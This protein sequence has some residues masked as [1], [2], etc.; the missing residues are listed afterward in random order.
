MKKILSGILAA[1]LAVG[2][3]AGC[4]CSKTDSDLN[5]DGKVEITVGNWPVNEGDYL[6]TITTQKE[7]FERDNPTMAIKPDN[8]AFSLDTFYSKAAAGMLPDLYYS[9]LTEIAAI[10]SGEYYTNISE[11]LKRAGYEGKINPAVLELITAE[12][13][14]I[15][16]FPTNAYSLG[17]AYNVDLFEK[18]GL[19]NEDGT[20]MQPKT[21]EEVAQFAK[22]ITEATGKAGFIIPTIDNCG[23]WLTTPIAWGYGVDFMEQDDAGNWKATFDCPEM[24]ETLQFISDLK[25]KHNTFLDNSLISLTEEYKQFALGNVG[26]IIASGDFT[27]QVYSYEMPL[28]HIGIMAIPAGPV[29][30]VT[31]VGGG[32]ATIAD[33]AT[34]RQVDV[35]I[36]WLE[37][38]GKGMNV[39]ATADPESH[40]KTMTKNKQAIGIYGMSV[41]SDD[42]PNVV[43][44]REMIE[45]YRNIDV[46]HVK[47]Y[48]EA[49]SDPSIILQAEEPVCAQELYSVIDGLVQ[50][51]LT[52]KNADIK[53]LV[54]AANA[55][56]QKNYLDNLD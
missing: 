40:Y 29:K 21:W 18:A 30:H 26:M 45:K 52:N 6:T 51:V 28:E 3:L 9:N 16:T 38:T 2:L 32:C 11:G 37:K 42:A 53:G 27:N 41:F 48:N 34:E 13:G 46:N 49:L 24:V 33:G 8:W 25:W 43:F 23:G 1:T 31:L 5:A 55:E 56:F 4:G 47:L 12:N 22:K 7:E 36:K 35:A 17:L 14:D 39:V 54:S 20:P 50:E 15:V 10:E 19:M 44:Q